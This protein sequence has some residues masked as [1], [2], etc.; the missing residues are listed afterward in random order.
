MPRGPRTRGD[1][2][3]RPAPGAVNA[4]ARGTVAER[5]A[6]SRHAARDGRAG[7][8]PVAM[9]VLGLCVL[10]SKDK[11]RVGVLGWRSRVGVLLYTWSPGMRVDLI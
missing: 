6:R 5:S 4:R 11:W 9:I 2:P 1:D 10:R 8:N 7:A 3:A